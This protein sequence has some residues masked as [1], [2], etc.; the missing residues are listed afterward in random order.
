MEA[1][2]EEDEKEREVETRSAVPV[3][4]SELFPSVHFGTRWITMK[5]KFE[6]QHLINIPLK[7][8][9]L[10]VGIEESYVSEFSSF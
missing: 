6:N 10:Y 8:A 2:I 4:L 7:N 3:V 9:Q 1:R 5:R